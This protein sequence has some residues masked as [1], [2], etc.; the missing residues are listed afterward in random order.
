MTPS[1]ATG[2]AC[3]CSGRGSAFGYREMAMTA[4]YED[5][6]PRMPDRAQWTLAARS[7]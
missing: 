1:P 2:R 4:Y 6:E 7:Y 5:L 3:R